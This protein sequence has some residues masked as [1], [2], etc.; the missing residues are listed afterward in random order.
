[1]NCNSL[2]NTIRLA[3]GWQIVSYVKQGYP[4]D[5]TGVACFDHI[6]TRV[7]PACRSIYNKAEMIDFCRRNPDTVVVT[8]NHLSLDVPA[9]TRCIIVHHGIAKLHGERDPAWQ[10]SNVELIAGQQRMLESRRPHNTVIVSCSEFCTREFDRLYSTLYRSFRHFAVPHMSMLELYVPGPLPTPANRALPVVCGDWRLPHKGANVIHAVQD[11]LKNEFKFCQMH[12]VAPNPF[13]PRVFAANKIAFYRSC[14]LMLCLS[15]HEGNSY[16]VLD[17]LF[18]GLPLVTTDVG[19]AS[20]IDGAV[21]LPWRQ[22]MQSP[23]MVADAVRQ[24]WRTSRQSR[25]R[26]Q[27]DKKWSRRL[28]VTSMTRAVRSL[29]DPNPSGK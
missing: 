26:D 24:A 11:L 21:V 28:Y 12:V 15:S 10:R 14:D 16:F 13:D 18:C 8:D 6:L 23:D 29:C 19:L 1:M 5:I 20:E 25:M 22:A 4:I 7:A 9:T 27:Y 2:L 3:P 17:G